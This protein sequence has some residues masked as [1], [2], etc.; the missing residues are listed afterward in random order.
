VALALLRRAVNCDV[1]NNTSVRSRRRRNQGGSLAR[2]GVVAVAG[3]PLEYSGTGG[4]YFAR[5][6]PTRGVSG[7]VIGTGRDPPEGG[8]PMLRC[9]L[10]R[11]RGRE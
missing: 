5:I 11:W 1:P 8:T 2:A 4:S 7:D 3:R 10:Q 9:D 6:N